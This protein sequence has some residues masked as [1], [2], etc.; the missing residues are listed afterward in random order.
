MA[1]ANR[2]RAI[3]L[4]L[5]S[6]CNLSCAYCYQNRKRARRMDW[7]TARAAVDFLFDSVPRREVPA[8]LLR[9]RAAA[10]AAPDPPRG[11]VRPQAR[12]GDE[13]IRFGIITNGTLV[14]D[15]TVH[16][17]AD[18]R[19]DTRLSFDGVRAAQNQ[20][21]RGSFSALDDTFLERLRRSFPRSSS[22][23]IWRSASR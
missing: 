2:V 21:S 20:R 17:L 22:A 23:T 11:G 14:D 19:F 1:R 16:F 4:V 7:S 5:T 9:R 18:H 13:R 12:A 6:A 8:E 10:R 15:A 3:D